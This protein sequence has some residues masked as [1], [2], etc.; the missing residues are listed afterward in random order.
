MEEPPRSKL[1]PIGVDPLTGVVQPKLHPQAKGDDS[2]AKHESGGV[3]CFG[4]LNKIHV[5]VVS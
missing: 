5:V 1:H 2:P 4:V 3:S